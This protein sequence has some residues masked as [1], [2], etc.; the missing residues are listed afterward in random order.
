MTGFSRGLRIDN[1]PK[2]AKV[3]KLVSDNPVEL[4]NRFLY[5]FDPKREPYHLPFRLFDFQEK[6]VGNIKDAIEN[7]YDLF[8]EKCRE[9]G[10]SYVTLATLLWFW[11]FIPG[12]NFLLGSR[13]EQF[14]DNRGVSLRKDLE[15]SNKEESLFGKLQYMLDHLNPLLLPKGFN[16]KRHFTTMSLKNP[17]N[18]NVISGESS[19]PNFSRGARYKAI[20]LDEFAFWE[21]DCLRKDTE[22]LTGLG[23]KLVKDCTKKDLVYSMD[24]DT[25]KAKLM[26]ITKLHKVYAEKLYE[27]K[28]KA[29]DISCT[30]NHKLLIKKRYFP[31]NTR[32]F[33]NKNKDK[34]K[35]QQ[36][37]GKMYFR[38]A[39]EV[40]TQ[41]HDFIPLVSNYV[42]GESPEKIYGFKA[43]D[44]LEFLGWYI[45]EGWGRNKPRNRRISISQTKSK[46]RQKIEDLLKRMNLPIVYNSHAYNLSKGY[47]PEKMFDELISLGKAHQK[48]IPR[49]Y[50]NLSK[51]LLKTLFNSLISGD[52]CITERKN[53]TNK[54]MY[55][56]TSKQLADDFQELTQKVGLKASIS[57]QSYDNG[58]WRKLYRLNIG[59]KQHSQVACLDKKIVPYND[60][61]YCVTTPYHSLYVRRNGRASWCGNTS[62]WGATADT[63]ACR[64]VLT[65]PGSRPSKAKRLRFGKDNEK[66]KVVTLTYNLDPRKTKKWL[67]REKNRRSAEDFAREIMINWETSVAGRVYNEIEQAEVGSFP[68]DW[69]WPLYVVWDFGLDG[70]ALQWW[71]TNMVNGKPRLVEAFENKDKP[72]EWFL[73]FFPKQDIDSNFSYSD[74]ELELIRKVKE[75]KIAIHYGDPDVSKRSLITGTSTRQTLQDKGIYVQTN[76]ESN[77]FVSRREKTKVLLQQGIEVNQ[78]RGTD[79]FMDC[80]KEARYPQR[81]ET[82]QVTTPVNLPI[83]DWTSHNRTALEYFAVNYEGKPEPNPITQSTPEE[84]RRNPNENIIP[85]EG[86]VADLF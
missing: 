48:H 86:G 16:V 44:F 58:K 31:K 63:T 42:D 81:Q 43:K 8:I 14:V 75:F 2:L 77:D 28:N 7:G 18:G 27:F 50:L 72:I 60:F 85:D 46:N 37:N 53:R 29:I 73:P 13:K 49:K 45:S 66:I 68:Y 6:L 69:H 24:I 34:G 79:Y 39:D 80:V 70:T 11:R 52:G 26:P 36:S 57:Q 74:D 22:V 65:T 19:N 83:H 17:Q 54:M 32:K 23:W 62:A 76:T 78:T 47:L 71:Q 59:F 84:R 64:I 30:A 25:G 61:T 20:L 9:V 5:T 55:A 67:A 51:D 21:N 82:S 15:V 35:Y 41:K 10:A 40:Y 1:N 4:T 33:K 3:V 12:S 56:T 38:R